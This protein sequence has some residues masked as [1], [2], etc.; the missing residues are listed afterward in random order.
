MKNPE[1]IETVIYGG[2]FN[3]PTLA[4]QAILQAAVDY[5]GTRG[6]EVWI[7]PSGDRVD[8]TIPTTREQRLAYIDAMVADTDN[9]GV[10]TSILMTEL[11][12]TI[13][14]ETYDTVMELEQDYPEREFRWL[15]GADSTETMGEWHHGDWLLE[16]L[17]MLVVSREG[18][19][20]NPLARRAIILT[21]PHFE[22]SSTELRRRLEQGEP[23]DDMVGGHVYNILTSI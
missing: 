7:M 8:K 9:E 4:H 23:F 2:A 20:I 1:R 11:D 17:A 10:P 13:K 14:I 18:H 22:L 21:I 5:A 15:F 16:N 12:R 3:P 19:T 6:G